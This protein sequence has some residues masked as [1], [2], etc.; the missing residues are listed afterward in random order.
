MTES[1]HLGAA[2]LV[3]RDTE[4]AALRRAVSAAATGSGGVLLVVG[5]AGVGKSRLVAAATDG[6]E[7]QGLRV[8]RGRATEHS[9]AYRP[10]AEAF[11]RAGVAVRDL[12]DLPALRPYRAALARLLPGWDDDPAQRTALDVDPALVLGEGVAELLLALAAG[13]GCVLVL[14]DLHWADADTLALVEYLADRLQHLPV[15][16]VA[17]ARDD[18]PGSEVMH[19][20]G[21]QRSVQRVVLARL[22]PAAC[23]ALA[24]ERSAGRLDDDRAAELAALSEGLPLLVEELVDE[25]VL[26]EHASAQSPAAPRALAALARRRLALL[27]PDQQRCLE[28]A[29]VTGTE[30]EWAVI[31]AAVGQPESQV[32]AAARAAV[33]AGLLRE[34][35]DGVTWRHALTREAVLSGLLAPERAALSVRVADALLARGRPED[36]VQAAELLAA[37]GE[38]ERAAALFLSLA[39]DAR[40]AGNL[41]L[42][43]TLLNHAQAAGCDVAQVAHERVVLLTWTGRMPEAVAVGVAALP[44]AAGDLHVELCL[45]LARAAV[46]AR[47]WEDAE[48]FVLW[49]GRPEDPRSALLVADAAFGAGDADRAERLV[50]EAV[51]RAERSGSPAVLGEALDI[52]GRVARIRDPQLARGFFTRELQVAAEHR[53]AYH[54]I[55]ALIGLGTL[56]LLRDEY[57]PSESLTEA[58]QVAT[59]AGMLG[60]AA[61]AQVIEL[62]SSRLRDGPARHEETATA[63]LAHAARLHLRLPEV[64][65]G[66][67][68]VRAAARAAAD[69]TAGMEAALAGIPSGWAEVDAQVAAVRA[70]PL[71]LRHDLKGANALLDPHVSALVSRR[72]SVPWLEFGLWALLRTAVDD[73]ADEARQA[74]AGLPSL[75]RAGNRAALRYAEAIA[76]GRAG[77]TAEAVALLEAGDSGLDG[78]PWT[79]RMWRLLVLESCVVDGWGDPVPHLRH[80]LAE[81]ERH[82]DSPLARTCRDL[83]RQAGSPV[84]RG[85]G[86]AAVPPAL[87]ARGVTSRE[88]DVLRL[89]ADGRTNAEIAEQLFLSRRTVETHVA[90]LLGK[91]DASDRRELRDRHNADGS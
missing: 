51:D 75:N 72:T 89:V 87:R 6:A 36:A 84:R 21:S 69:D 18:E 49:A 85:R 24:R 45:S 10:V 74:L 5:E 20:L 59:E 7:Q 43:A 57:T 26:G 66:C 44:A 48:K 91:L 46:G 54:R 1:P 88:L 86:D 27:E 81:H 80:D 53:I 62:Q 15:L 65:V 70:L 50:A 47:R 23:L 61:A 22:E 4:A 8:L 58:V 71:I 13:E 73:R 77:R 60:L 82:G 12:A 34:D 17:S 64:Q 78:L 29:A 16:V 37:G 40:V 42:A 63:L 28:V 67:A 68:L 35:G 11:L 19:R 38:A 55:T 41:G 56:E 9:G 79:R 90:N 2:A 83:L 52:A 31:P 33:D 32:L 14:E 25:A 76:A 3:G 39:R 30:P